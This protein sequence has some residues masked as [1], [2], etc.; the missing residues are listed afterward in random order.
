MEKKVRREGLRGRGKEGMR[1]DGREEGKERVR[2]G[3]G[4]PLLPLV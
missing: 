3:E 4:V 2:K 1:E